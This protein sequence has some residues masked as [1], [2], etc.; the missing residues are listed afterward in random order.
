MT[1]TTKITHIDRLIPRRRALRVFR[2]AAAALACSALLLPAIATAQKLNT[3]LFSA[4]YRVQISTDADWL[5]HPTGQYVDF[6][7]KK[8]RKKY[9]YDPSYRETS[10]M[11]TMA[12]DL[13]AAGYVM[14]GF[15]A[16]NTSQAGTSLADD[17]Y[18]QSLTP[19]EQAGHRIGLKIRGQLRAATNPVGDAR[20]A[21]RWANAA[22]VVLQRD[23]SF[24]QEK[25]VARRVVASDAHDRT[26]SFG[27]NAT[28]QRE[29]YSNSAFQDGSYAH[30]SGG[31]SASAASSYDDT[32]V[33]Q[34]R[35]WSTV[36]MSETDSHFD[37]VATF[38][39]KADPREF[40]L[41]VLTDAV[42]GSLMRAVGTR[43]G[44]VVRTV[45]AGTPAWDADLWE[46]DVLLGIDGER[47]VS[48]ERFSSLIETRRGQ[49]A[50]LTV[51][52]QGDLYELP[53]RF[54]R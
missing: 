44:R 14:I 47:V 1:F 35:Q 23:F 21:A 29:R 5:I 31:S 53:V 12:A 36:L 46:G 24:Q 9:W 2:R 48:A 38:W 32:T 11:D 15:S 13:V 25:T 7:V 43:H 45:V 40:V 16:F 51:W 6:G 33:H 54:N 34:S 10:D 18:Y 52:R 20:D 4:H 41:G 27:S 49:D 22:L 42:P 8:N 39:K 50:L 30:S 37:Y 26:R 3:G 28:S 17:A 19:A